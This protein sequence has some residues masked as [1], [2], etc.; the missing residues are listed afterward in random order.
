[1]QAIPQ[2]IRNIIPS[3][4]K[5]YINWS[6]KLPSGLYGEYAM[7]EWV[8]GKVVNDLGIDERLEECRDESY[9]GDKG[10]KS[11]TWPQWSHQNIIEVE[12]DQRWRDP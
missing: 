12:I 2:G 3:I 8:A 6:Q 1:M 5:E 7:H 10:E 9:R 4:P 11:E